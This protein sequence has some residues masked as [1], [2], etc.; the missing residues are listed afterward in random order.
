MMLT[1]TLSKEGLEHLE[2]EK[3]SYF[4]TKNYHLTARD[5]IQTIVTPAID[6]AVLNEEIENCFD[7][8]KQ[9]GYENPIMI[10]AIPFDISRNS[11]LNFY[12]SYEK[13]QQKNQQQ[14]NLNNSSEI[15]SK[16]SLI[17]KDRFTEN[18]EQ[19]LSTFSKK[20]LEKIVLSQAVE[21]E[22]EDKQNPESLLYALLGQNPYAFNFVIPVDEH[23]YILG[24]SP[25]LLLA[26]QNRMVMSNP[27]AGSRPRSKDLENNAR[28]KQEL[29]DSVK[30]QNEHKIVVDNILKNLVSHCVE[31]K[32]SEFPDILETS[33]MLHLSS[34]FQGI[35]KSSA[36]NALNLALA[37]HPTPAV[38]GSPTHLAKQFILEHEGYDRNYYT[39][40]VG[41]MDANG[42]GEWV[43]TIRCGLLNENKM[44]LYAGAGIVE[45]SNAEA[46]W[47]ETEVKMQTMLNIFNTDT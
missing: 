35:L 13:L 34:E 6:K 32:V 43:V 12:A 16:F 1:E 18:V 20:E 3:Y 30:D 38:C 24:A 9:A 44:R 4:S 8:L 10:G 19:A 26:K 22:F 28:R 17:H 21:Y 37:L 27:L 40:L 39:G 29:H 36:P 42:N 31:L 11:S 2:N 33:T 23:D 15:V 25:E 47:H 14:I 5:F 7:R 41:W 46:E 45:G